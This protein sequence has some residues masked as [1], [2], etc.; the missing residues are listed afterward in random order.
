M[1][2]VPYLDDVFERRGTYLLGSVSCGTVEQSLEG[3]SIH[4]IFD[5]GNQ[6][7]SSLLLPSL[8]PT[9]LE[10]PPPPSTPTSPPESNP[11]PA[12]LSIPTVSTNL[13]ILFNDV[14]FPR[15]VHRISTGLYR[16][17]TLQ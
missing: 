4:R 2:T 12:H 13:T 8:L 1:P 10:H 6:R 14:P 11:I 7:P 5:P 15:R 3:Q 17:P 9:L 16:L